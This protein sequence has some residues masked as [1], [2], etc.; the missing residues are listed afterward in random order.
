MVLAEY[1][2]D[3]ERVCNPDLP[4]PQPENVTTDNPR[5]M[6]V[7]RPQ[8]WRNDQAIDVDHP[9]RFDATAKILQRSAE[10]IRDFKHNNYDSDDLAED[11]PARNRHDGPFEVD[12]DL[13]AW[14]EGHGIMDRKALTEEQ[15][16][17]I[18]QRYGLQ[19][20]AREVRDDKAA[21]AARRTDEL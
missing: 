13:D 18:R 1:L 4:Q 2:A 10:A 3:P 9:V 5:L 8:A 17:E 6:A 15:W 11:L 20:A 14:L 16:A 21:V 19:P 7:F 12:V